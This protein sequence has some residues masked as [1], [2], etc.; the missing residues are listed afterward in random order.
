MAST[1]HQF[2]Y[3]SLTVNTCMFVYRK[4]RVRSSL[5]YMMH[6]FFLPCDPVPYILH[7]IGIF[8]YLFT[9]NGSCEEADSCYDCTASNDNIIRE[10]IVKGLEG[11]GR[12]L[13]LGTIPV[14]PPPKGK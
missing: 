10:L 6:N 1:S 7:N 11:S 3:Q 13:I 12:G 4:G 5:N 2:G 8:I 14:T 9:V